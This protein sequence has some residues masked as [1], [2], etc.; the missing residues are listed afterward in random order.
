M[1][2]QAMPNRH[3]SHLASL[4]LQLLRDDGTLIDLGANIGTVCLPVAA[5]GRRVI[6]VEMNPR[7]VLKLALA[8]LVNRFP[9]L[10]I[11]Q[12]A[13]TDTDGVVGHVGDAAWGPGV[14][15]GGREPRP[16]TKC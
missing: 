16:H 14:Q 13:V 8:A 2:R 5:S 11:V 7:N 3:F 10:R 12:A 15:R 6:A 1:A 4:F 9:N